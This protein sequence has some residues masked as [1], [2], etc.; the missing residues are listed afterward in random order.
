MMTFTNL[1][2]KLR[3]YRAWYVELSADERQGWLGDWIMER[4]V[5]FEG[6]AQ[7]LARAVA[8]VSDGGHGNYKPDPPNI[9]DL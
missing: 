9:A 4:I 6:I 7:D 2:K 5:I 1:V 3:Y 8:R